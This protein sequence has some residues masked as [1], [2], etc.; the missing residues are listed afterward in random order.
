M[1]DD[2]NEEKT[3]QPTSHKLKEAKKKGNKRHF[4][5]LNS[6]LILVSALMIFWFKKKDIAI[7][8]ETIMRSSLV[9]DHDSLRQKY[10]FNVDSFF[11]L[12]EVIFFPMFL[13]TLLSII[14]SNFNF[15]IQFLRVNFSTLNPLTGFK[16]LFS[17]QIILELFKTMLKVFLVGYVV[18]CHISYFF[19]QSLNF[20]NKN[21]FFV[22]QNSFFT[23]FLC[24]L[25]IL[26]TIIP[27]VVF[28]VFWERYNYY[29]QL[30]MTRQEVR[31]EFKRTEGN[32]HIKSHIRR[33][34]RE[35]ARRRML[36]NVSKSDVIII[37]P[38]HYAIA[39]QYNEKSM[40]APKILAKGSGELALKIQKIGNK[41]SIPVLFSSSLARV[42]Y[43]YTDIGQCI[44][45]KLYTA[46]AE[47]LAWVWKI[48][49]WRKEGGVFPKQPNNFFIP[50][51]LR[52][53]GEDKN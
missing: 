39:L 36:S 49:S 35:I 34:M 9:F 52:T 47:V 15:H 33:I 10:I 25:I 40:K 2:N 16:K 51:E 14:C 19:L 48:R 44:P 17:S 37:N 38:V 4:R 45:N 29:K 18:Y 43:H 22:L 1:S 11:H 27:I 6:L 50:L 30:R 42:L 7:S 13:T 31:D 3:E 12:F 41:H 20:I 53:L 8:F 28:D 5:E 24:I 23:I 21:V 26:V 46:V 32:P